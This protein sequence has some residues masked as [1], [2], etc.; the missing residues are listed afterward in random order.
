MLDQYFECRFSTQS[1]NSDSCQT[2]YLKSAIDDHYR[3]VHAYCESCLKPFKNTLGL[4]EHLRQSSKHT[5][6]SGYYCCKCM[7]DYSSA[8]NLSEHIRSNTHRKKN[9]PCPFNCGKHSV[10]T[11]AAVLHLEAGTCRAGVNNK[12]VTRYVR[13]DGVS[14][15]ITDPSLMIIGDASSE[16][17][18]PLEPA[19]FSCYL[20][21]KSEFSSRA[22]L[23]QHLA[24]PAHGEAFYVCPLEACRKSFGRLSGIC[25]HIESGKCRVDESWLVRNALQGLLAR[26][27]S[28]IGKDLT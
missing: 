11:A 1:N 13:E 14:E 27:H 26:M 12:Y 17:V 4:Q 18:N 2:H 6:I 5:V 19:G 9:V 28:R 20:G 8:S 24:S 7:T 22:A 15:L 25:Q 23:Q 3:D 10:S 21:C 16:V